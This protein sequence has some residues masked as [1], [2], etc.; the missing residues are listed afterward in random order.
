[1]WSSRKPRLQ[2][3]LDEGDNG[4]GCSGNEGEVVQWV[5]DWEGGMHSSDFIQHFGGYD[6]RTLQYFTRNG[7]DT[8]RWGSQGGRAFLLEDSGRVA[9]VLVVGRQ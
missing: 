3:A 4:K 2:R 1:M 6:E 7:F 8:S 5:V 9:V